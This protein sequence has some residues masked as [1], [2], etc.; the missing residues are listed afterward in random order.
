MIYEYAVSPDLFRN[1]ANLNLLF[2]AFE[3]GSGRL[4]SDY[5]RQKLFQY[6]RSFIKQ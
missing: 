1:P 3:A 2:Q 4:I 6:V 5:P